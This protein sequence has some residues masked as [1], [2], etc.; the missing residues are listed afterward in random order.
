MLNA[1]VW[2]VIP[3]RQT[4]L[5]SLQKDDIQLIFG[6][7]GD[8]LDMDSFEALQASG[9]LKTIMSDPVASRAIVLNSSRPITSDK[10]VR[11]ALEYAVD[12]DG[13]ASGIL[14]NSETVAETLMAKTV[15]YSNIDLPVYHFDQD[16]ARKLLDESGWILTEG[17]TIR[18]KNGKKWN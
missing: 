9:K 1:V 17:K 4:L 18:E 8:M 2:K 3:D 12:K 5:L 14:D 10:K 11:Q 6:A 16:K 13:I 7:D 15:P